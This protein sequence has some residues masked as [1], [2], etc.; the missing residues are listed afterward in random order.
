M[1]GRGDEG[2]RGRGDVQDLAEFG[3]ISWGEVYA[4]A[5]EEMTERV[6]NRTVGYVLPGYELGV[7]SVFSVGLRVSRRPVLEDFWTDSTNAQAWASTES[8]GR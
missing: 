2:M 3:E 7:H 1:R 8:L 6:V 4:V 5:V